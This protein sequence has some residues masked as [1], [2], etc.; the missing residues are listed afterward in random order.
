MAPFS[1]LSLTCAYFQATVTGSLATAAQSAATT[2]TTDTSAM[3]NGINTACTDLGTTT[4]VVAISASEMLAAS[5]TVT[6][7]QAPPASSTVEDGGNAGGDSSLIIIIVVVMVVVLVAIAGIS[8]F[9]LRKQPEN[10]KETGEASEETSIELTH[11]K[12][13]SSTMRA[14]GTAAHLRKQPENAKETGEATEGT[15]FELKA[16]SSTM[17]ARGTAAH[18]RRFMVEI[19]EFLPHTDLSELDIINEGSYCTVYKATFRGETV[20]MKC[21]K[22]TVDKEVAEKTANRELRVLMRFNHP[23]IVALR[24][25]C[26]QDGVTYLLLQFAERKSLRH[27]LDTH[28][29]LQPAHQF[30]LS[31]GITTG[32]DA[33]QSQGFLHRDLKS[34]N[35][36][37]TADWVAVLADFGLAKVNQESNA[38]MSSM[39]SSMMTSG[40]QGAGTRAYTA[41]ELIGGG[42]YTE[43]Y[44][45]ACEV[46]AYGLVLFELWT[47]LS[48]HEAWQQKGIN[49][50]NE[51]AFMTAVV[52][53]A[54]LDIPMSAVITEA[55]SAVETAHTAYQAA[56]STVRQVGWEQSGTAAAEEEL[57]AAAK[58]LSEVDD[59]AFEDIDIRTLIEQCWQTNPQVAFDTIIWTCFE[60]S[61]DAGSSHNGQYQ[62]RLH[63]GSP[64]HQRRS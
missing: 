44:N 1:D 28:A 19:N 3:V 9:L 42:F 30:R 16:L 40:G 52:Q 12:D 63:T 34:D 62:A 4:T 41:P 35:I 59:F 45:A 24:G 25:V 57:V 13:L 33:L 56:M 29:D 14:H 61:F 54:R 6:L 47:V 26:K 15:S 27:V 64:C 2:L 58:T 46:Y 50:Q 48:L 18:L 37:V 10:V 5:P 55:R 7:A 22:T 49:L 23:N 36:L 43:S 39:M 32:L 11:V 8:Y 53:G 38:M 31:H 60:C 20:A 17:R 21:A 51:Y